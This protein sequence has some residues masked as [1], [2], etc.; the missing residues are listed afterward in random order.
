MR[1]RRL[2]VLSLCGPALFLSWLLASAERAPAQS[3]SSER[4]SSAVDDGVRVKTI[5]KTSKFASVVLDKHCPD[6]VEPYKLTDNIASLAALAAKETAA[7]LG[8]GFANLFSGSTPNPQWGNTILTS[9]KLAAKQLNWL[10]M[11]TE[12]MIGEHL[13]REETNVL[14]RETSAGRRHYPVA[15]KMMGDVLTTLT[16]PHEYEFKLFILKNSTRNAIARPGGFI[17]LDQGLLDEPAQRPKA[18]FALSHE[19]AHVLQRH[20]TKEL[21]S[22]LVDSVS[23]AEDLVKMIRNAKANPSA[24]VAQVK[25]RKDL[26]TRHHVDQELQADSCAVR[27]LDRVFSSPRELADSLNAFL[28]DLP[29]AEPSR[30][31]AAAGTDVEKLTLTVHDIVDGPVKRHPTP[32]ERLENLRTM[33]REIVKAAPTK[34]R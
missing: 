13:H 24:I 10:P 4:P 22:T 11:P 5:T 3:A 7:S 6:I 29:P 9:T 15:D 23:S 25:L 33:Y 27:L 17:Y 1:T 34:S 19:L 26:F 12:V 28:R 32:Q 18:Y 30:P 31:A 16:E 20:E 14:G 2:R 8:K 21:Q